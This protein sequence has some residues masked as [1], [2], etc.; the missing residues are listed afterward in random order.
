MAKVISI[1]FPAKYALFTG[2]SN[3]LGYWGTYAQICKAIDVATQICWNVITAQ[4]TEL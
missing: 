4:P 3:T 1:I 2:R